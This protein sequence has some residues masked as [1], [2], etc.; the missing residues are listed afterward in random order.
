MDVA[1]FHARNEVRQRRW[2][3]TM[4]TTATHDTK[5]GEDVRARLATLSEVPDD[6][7]AAVE[8]WHEMNDRHRDHEID[9]P[10]RHDEWFIYQTLAGAHPLPADRAW[11]VLEK[12]LREAKRR[13]DWVRVDDGYERATHRF[14]DAILSDDEFRA[15]FDRMVESLVEPGYINAASQVALR[16]LSPGVPDTYQGTELWDS[17]L[18]DPDNRR[19]VDFDRRRRDLEAIRDMSFEELWPST[20]AKLALVQTCLALRRRTGN[21]YTRLAVDGA[22][23]D[24]VIAFARGGSVV[25]VVARWPMRGLP[26]GATIELPA[27]EWTNVLTGKPHSGAPTFGQLRGT[28]PLAL[29]ELDL[30]P[31]G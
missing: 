29:L 25:A 24:Q 8:R 23:A 1:E 11:T 22:A 27:G 21:D 12:S 31:V 2:P 19:P 26:D 7:G 13:T 14:L 16:L 18:V 20:R 4:L 28:A 6:W 3:S 30:D 15:D 10:G 9:A 17:S 5:R